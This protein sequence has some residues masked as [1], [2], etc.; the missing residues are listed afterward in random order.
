MT[1]LCEE[2]SSLSDGTFGSDQIV[3]FLKRFQTQLKK[4]QAKHGHQRTP[5]FIYS[6][7]QQAFGRSLPLNLNLVRVSQMLG[8]IPV[9]PSWRYQMESGADDYE[10]SSEDH[11]FPTHSL[12]SSFSDI[13]DLLFEECLVSPSSEWS[14]PVHQSVHI[15]SC[16]NVRERALVNLSRLDDC[17]DD[18][19]LSTLLSWVEK[20]RT[21]CHSAQRDNFIHS[22]LVLKRI[23]SF[24]FSEFLL[25]FVHNSRSC[26]PVGDREY[27]SRHS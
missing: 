16:S 7:L 5:G 26:D 6:I 23:E 14:V 15:S 17:D 19:S 12:S 3:D 25:L 11:R 4:A 10:T 20:S 24:V 9:K 13:H 21:F 8:S 1:S 2:S 18:L 27:S 22:Q